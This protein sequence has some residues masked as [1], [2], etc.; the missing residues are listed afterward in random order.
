MPDGNRRHRERER[1]REIDWKSPV[2]LFTN[3]VLYYVKHGRLY[4]AAGY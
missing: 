2:L 4:M 1:E 3:R